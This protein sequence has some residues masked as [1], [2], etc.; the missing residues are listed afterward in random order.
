MT[1]SHPAEAQPTPDAEWIR[2]HYTKS[3]H[4]IPMRDGERLFTA[5]Y[6]P[7]DAEG[8]TPFL[9]VRTPY[10]VGPYGE[11]SYPSR[12][13]PSMALARE[14]YIFVYQDVRGRM[15]SEGDFVA[16]RPHNPDKTGDEIDESSDTYD[17]VEWLLENVDGHNGRVGVWGISAPGFYA[18][19]TLLA[20]HPAI[21]AVSPQAPVT[22]WWIGDDRHHN[23]AFQL[24]A[25][26]SFLS[27]YGQERPE[28]TT[29][30]ASG[31]SDY[32]TDDGYRWYLEQGP[33]PNFTALIPENDLWR[34]MM[35][36]GDYDA[37]W[38]A[39]TPLPHLT[40]VSAAVLVT[41]GFFDAQDLYGPL[42]TYQALEEKNPETSVYLAMGPWWHGGW[43]RGAG[44]RYGDLYFEQNT[45][46]FYRQN[47]EAPF[48]EYHLKDQGAMNL[49]PASI[50]VTG[51]NRWHF[52]DG[53]PAPAAEAQS[54][55]LQPEGGLSFE[56]PTGSGD[57]AEYVSDP[58]KP[59][60]HTPKTVITRDD[61][62]VVQDQ[63]F[64]ATRPDVLVFESEPLTEDVTLTG[65]LFATLFVETTG[66]DADFIVKL[67]DVYPGDAECRLPDG[68]CDVPQG[69]FQMLVRGEVMRAKY[70]NSFETPEP[71]TPGE[72]A[73]VTFDMQDVAH[74]FKRGHR[75]MV[76]VQSSWFPM[77]DR[78]PQT[79]TDIYHASEE[80]FQTAT[81][82]IQLSAEY[83][84]HLAVKR[85]D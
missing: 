46:E 52:F 72:V 60:P 37:W 33:L 45:A 64:A 23:G 29:E 2:A 47:I 76:Q 34:D 83:P 7:N 15:M 51:S 71:L 49:E 68:D 54:L 24:Q 8:E 21:R 19:H 77:V 12:L 13:G 58:N 10:G 31:F 50:F 9:M 59:V 79:F 38:Q 16:V 55:Y 65:D 78:N 18:T 85:L 75:I 53:W 30:Y 17:T 70:R 11:D 4:Y 67:I 22:D 27:F 66:T 73:E 80:D 81:H 1:A 6:T 3:E 40:D 57:F 61:R 36:H 84:S 69:H 14:G 28:P 62:Y 56:A 63:R 43:A 42:K 41:G 35:E 44:D 20:D 48:F 26:F 32:G 82:R 5:I 39:R 25:S 74:T